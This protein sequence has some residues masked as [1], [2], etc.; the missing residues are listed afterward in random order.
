MTKILIY[1]VASDLY[2]RPLVYFYTLEKVR[3]W[4]WA[5]L[6][7][8]TN[9]SSIW[10]QTN[11]RIESPWMT[12]TSIHS[13]KQQYWDSF[14][15]PVSYLNWTNPRLIVWSW[16]S[17]STGQHRLFQ[18]L[19]TDQSPVWIF[20]YDKNTNLHSWKQ[21]YQTSIFKAFIPTC[22]FTS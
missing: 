11:S 1:P 22:T 9:F 10:N 8:N 4:V 7:T 5:C 21:W 15:R 3:N 17:A 2:S 20:F 12:K 14:F 13:V 18:A 16:R 19:K 6:G